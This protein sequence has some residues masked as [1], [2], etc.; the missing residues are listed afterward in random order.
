MM[1][2]SERVKE[3]GSEGGK[4]GEREGRTDGKRERLLTLSTPPVTI[5]DPFGFHLRAKIGPE[6]WTRVDFSSPSLVHIRATPS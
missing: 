3:G 4:E 6:C 5:H 2:Y 1:T